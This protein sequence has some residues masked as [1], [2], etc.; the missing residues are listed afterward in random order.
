MDIS[1]S[2]GGCTYTIKN[3]PYFWPA[4]LACAASGQIDMGLW[5]SANKIGY[6]WSW[7]THESRDCVFSFHE[8]PA[9]SPVQVSRR[10][11]T[12]IVGRIA[13]FGFYQQSDCFPYDMLTID[14][15]NLAYDFLGLDYAVDIRNASLTVTRYLPTSNTGGD[16]N[17]DYIE[18]ALVSEFL[19]TGH[20]GQWV[21]ALD[22]ALWKSEWQI[23][24]SDNFFD[25]DDPGPNNDQVPHTKNILSDDEHRYRGGMMMAFLMSGD[26]RI[27]GGLADE[28]E[29]LQDVYV[30]PQERSMYQTIVAITELG[31]IPG[32]Y[33]ALLP[34]LRN[35]LQFFCEPQ[36]DIDAGQLGFGWDGPPGLGPRGCYVNSD[37]NEDEKAPGETYVTRGFISASMGTRAMF[38]A[39]NYLGVGHPDGE[40]AHSRL[41]DLANYTRN[42]LYPF[43]PNPADRHMVYSYGVQ[44]KLVNDYEDSDFHPISIGMA[45][46]FRMTGDV[47]YLYKGAEQLEAFRA[48]NQM[49]WVDKRLE[50]QHFLRAVL[51]AAQQAGLL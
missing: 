8:G 17:H 9:P 37:Q 24:L 26:E 13:D 41:L 7:R 14:E 15:Q 1:A 44:Q 2:K 48:H 4:G 18:R 28:V 21:G 27:R 19:R 38:R 16:N 30:S 32:A 46:A 12:P 29:V 3:M 35:R 42:E 31:Q 43:F 51:D 47:G 33:A 49:Q 20:G 10:L 36:I 45:E 40:M 50:F 5:P 23:S 34:V 6:T 39:W 11:D 25:A 22:Q